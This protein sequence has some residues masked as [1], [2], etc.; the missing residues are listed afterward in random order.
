MIT[1]F[2]I[3]RAA[4][5]FGEL[6]Y[7]FVIF[8]SIILVCP[9][10]SSYFSHHF[11]TIPTL[12]WINVAHKHGVKVLGK[13]LLKAFVRIEKKFRNFSGTF[14]VESRAGQKIFNNDVLQS[15]EVARTVADALVFIAKECKFE[16]WLINV[17]CLVDENNVPILK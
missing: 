10:A 15:V 6:I 16:G 17:E 1:D 3:G 7:L 5:Y 11:I 2:T 4:I 13:F 9:V 14:I 12:Q 8:F